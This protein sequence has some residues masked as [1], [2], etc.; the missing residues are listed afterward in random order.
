VEE[1]AEKIT[2]LMQITGKYN[3]IKIYRINHRQESNPQ[4]LAVIGSDCQSRSINIAGIPRQIKNETHCVIRLH[5]LHIHFYFC[6]FTDDSKD[7]QREKTKERMS[8]GRKSR[9]GKC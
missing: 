4:S 7:V 8:S 6:L 9:I 2:D 1:T 3:K 5:D